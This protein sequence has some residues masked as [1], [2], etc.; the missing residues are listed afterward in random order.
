[1]AKTGGNTGNQL[2]AHG[3][4]SQI[5]YDYISWDHRVDPREVHE[6]F[7][8]IV[9]AAA[10][11][12]FPRFDFG[13]MAEYIEG[14]DLPV[15]IVGLGAQSN[16]YDPNISLLP[17]TE[18]FVKV[19]AER[20]AQIG[21]RGP[22]TAEVLARRGVQNVTVTGCPSYYMSGSK[23]IV[24]KQQPFDEIKHVAVNAS[25]DVIVHS[26]D[27]DRMRR[28]V[29]D[30]YRAGIEWNGDFV[31]QSEEVEIRLADFQSKTT[32]YEPLEELTT[33]LKDVASEDDV[34]SW[35]AEHVRVYFDVNDWLESIQEYDFV[36][37]NRFH[38]CMVALQRGVP[39]VVICHDTRTEDMCRF[40]ALPCISIVD[41]ERID[42]RNLYDLVDRAAF[43]NRYRDLYPKYAEFLAT[44]NLR[45]RKPG[46]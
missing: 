13:A 45:M 23:G 33:F 29:Q 1:M 15:S 5:E 2:I 25:R 42:V 40:L 35:A 30:I 20:A 27:K 26:F 8:M 38:G 32:V 43:T 44:N 36:F 14:A 24:L 6:R 9:I 46:S 10:N 22:Y 31:A 11:F 17:G 3:L 28:L 19:I 41:I 7:D 18:R 4:L 37:G 34:R 21:V 12:L 16:S 39:S